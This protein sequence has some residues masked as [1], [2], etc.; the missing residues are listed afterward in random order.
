[1]ETKKISLMKFFGQENGLIHNG[2]R[3]EKTNRSAA[4]LPNPVVAAATLIALVVAVLS[5]RQLL[6]LSESRSSRILVKT[7]PGLPPLE[8]ANSH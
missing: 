3:S 7:L 6:R 8:K 5:T 2:S 1:M 4:M